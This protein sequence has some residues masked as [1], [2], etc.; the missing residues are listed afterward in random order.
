MFERCNKYSISLNP[1]NSIF[2][3][4]KGKLLGHIVS[5]K[6][7]SIDPERVHSIKNVRPPTNKKSLQYIFGKINFIRQ[8]IPNFDE[9]F[10]PMNDLLKKDVAFRWD[11]NSLRSFKD[12]KDTITK[13]PILVNLDYSRYFI[14]FSFA[15]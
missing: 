15:S 2:G 7:I 8:F 11:N 10:R 6:G 4:D 3:I 14:I 9:R 5:E 13:A 12:I 1:K